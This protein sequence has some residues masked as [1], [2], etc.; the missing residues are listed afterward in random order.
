MLYKKIPYILCLF[1]LFSTVLVA[2]YNYRDAGLSGSI[3]YEYIYDLY[4]TEN[5]KSERTYFKENYKLGYKGSI[6]S[7]NLLSYDLLGSLAYFTNKNTS[8]GSK[9]TSKSETYSYG[10]TM[11]FIQKTRV[12][13][14]LSYNKVERPA[15]GTNGYSSESERKA[16]V[17]NIKLNLFVLNYGYS[18][19]EITSKSIKSISENN[20]ERYNM[21]V[22]KKINNHTVN[23]N[24]NH[25]NRELNRKDLLINESTSSKISD[26][27]L[28]LRYNWKISDELSLINNATYAYNDAYLSESMTIN[29]GLAWYPKS[30]YSA[31][32]SANAS[33]VNSY[34]YK[35][36]DLQSERIKLDSSQSIAIAQSFSYRMTKNLNLAQSASYSK[37]ASNLSNGENTGVRLGTRFS[38]VLISDIKLN[39]AANT[40]SRVSKSSTF[41]DNNVT[42]STISSSSISFSGSMSKHISL[43]ESTISTS[44]SYGVSNGSASLGSESYGASLSVGSKIFGFISNSL[45]SKYSES[46]SKYMDEETI[47]TRSVSSFS[48]IERVSMNNRIGIRGNI[49]TSGNIIYSKIYNEDD[50]LTRIL[51]SAIVALS[52][53]LFGIIN[54]SARAAVS[55]DIIYDTVNYTAGGALAYTAGKTTMSMDYSYNKSRLNVNDITTD[56]DRHNIRAK[57]QRIF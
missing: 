56:M 38:K 22:N 41:F 46:I 47:N 21:S 31:N 7:P 18:L 11:R 44:A 32:I 27:I 40:S 16:I 10:T 50:T 55:S 13:F 39:L 53:N 54:S 57:V 15:S 2:R 9:S 37:F 48:I 52:Y 30:N 14:A 20:S 25:N 33:A 49:S 1:L 5:S 3:G 23:V 6:Y 35:N 29:S 26:D 42:E 36:D 45:S 34:G 24:Y 12:P 17:G 8:A 51:P 19:S 43:I 4:N 28:R